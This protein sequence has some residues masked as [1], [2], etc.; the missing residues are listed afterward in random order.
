MAPQGVANTG[1]WDCAT[2][3]CGLNFT[4]KHSL[5]WANSGFLCS[6]ISAGSLWNSDF[7]MEDSYF[8]DNDAIVGHAWAI[9]NNVLQNKSGN[10]NAVIKRSRFEMTPR[11]QQPDRA[12]PFTGGG[13]CYVGLLP[14]GFFDFPG[15][16]SLQGA[17]ANYVLEDITVNG[18]RSWYHSGMFNQ[19]GDAQDATVFNY[20]VSAPPSL[21][22]YPPTAAKSECPRAFD[23]TPTL[24]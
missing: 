7:V 4:I 21:L 5:W 23:T 3:G 16:S 19:H 2:Q 18:W 10:F 20:N 11:C 8:V 14:T 22:E 12:N 6:G 24:C 1:G 9:G 13:F 17:T 15:Q